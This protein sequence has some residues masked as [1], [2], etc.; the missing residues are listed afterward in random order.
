MFDC[1]VLGGRTH[2]FVSDREHWRKIVRFAFSI[3][4]KLIPN[5]FSVSRLILFDSLFKADPTN[6]LEG[7]CPER[8]HFASTATAG[9]LLQD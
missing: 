4:L 3:P 8:D 1:E 7:S 6:W 2:R 9:R 5:Y